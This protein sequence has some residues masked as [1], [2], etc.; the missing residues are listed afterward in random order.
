MNRAVTALA[1]YRLA[2]KKG[3]S[4]ADAV[5]TADE[6][7]EM[8]HYDY[9]NT[10]RPRFMQGD[11]G[12]VVFLFRNYSLNMQYRLIRDF[13]DGIWRNENI[14]IE[15]RKEAR[16]RFLGIIG[17][18]TIFAGIAGY[19]LMWGVEAIANNML[20]DEDDPFDSKTE[21]RKLV[22]EATRDHIGEAWGQKVATAVMKGPWS[23]FTGADLS[24]RASLNN[25][26]IREIPEN[27]KDNPQDLMLHLAGEALGP[28][29]GVGMN[30][31][32]GIGDFQR[33]HPERGLEKFMPKF[34]GD[35]LKTF[36]YATQGAQ[37]YQRDMVVSPE[38][39]TNWSLFVQSQGFTPTRLS[40][41][42][43]QNRSIKDLEQKL[44]NRRSDLMNQL[45]MA[46]RVGDRAEARDVM[47]D[48]LV[49]NKAQPRYPISPDGIMQSAR[50][51]AQYDMRTVGGVAVDK[52]LQYLQE[53]QRFTARPAQ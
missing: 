34:A 44:R 9:T 10:N 38:E 32:G 28:I 49:W 53:Q 25:L 30:W 29:W 36:R 22:F 12:R 45:F 11:K 35:A 6:L 18:T 24:Q 33:G 20:G 21:M 52:R 14:P 50:T 47:Q 26:W 39:M 41:R 46:W 7:V 43:E 2:V 31:A 23:A 16:S 15:A 40:D 4:H 5:T 48:I 13:R 27:L 42:Y 8:S 51:R 1:A 19:P 17:M 3:Q 37:T